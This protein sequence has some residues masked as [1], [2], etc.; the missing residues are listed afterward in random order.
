[1][2]IIQQSYAVFDNI[3]EKTEFATEIYNLLMQFEK[4][5]Q[6]TL[7]NLIKLCL[8]K[9]AGGEKLTTTYKHLYS[10]TL[11]RPTNA[12]DVIGFGKHLQQIIGSIKDELSV[13]L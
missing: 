13:Q 7:R 2:E 1:M 4:Q 10:L 6:T 5:L 11:R 9:A 8:T 12:I 3:Q